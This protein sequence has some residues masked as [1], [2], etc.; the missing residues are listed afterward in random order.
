[1][2]IIVVIGISSA[3]GIP[4]PEDVNMGIDAATN[5]VHRTHPNHADF[6]QNNLNTP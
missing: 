5:T 1:M 3:N 6:N 4:P 2:V